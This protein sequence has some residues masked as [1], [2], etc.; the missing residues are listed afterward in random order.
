MARAGSQVE[1]LRRGKPTRGPVGTENVRLIEGFPPSFVESLVDVTQSLLQAKLHLFIPAANAAGD[2][3]LGEFESD[4]YSMDCTASECQSS[5]G[6][7][8]DCEG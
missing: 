1:K 5:L 6:W 3:T 7:P 2:V 8:S 4:D